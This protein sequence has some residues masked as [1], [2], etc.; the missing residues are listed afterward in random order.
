MRLAAH[1]AGMGEKRN[2]Y[3]I[4]RRKPQNQS[5]LGRPWHWWENNIKM[6]IMRHRMGRCRLD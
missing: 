2:A 5:P 6:D 4:L 3:R 1:I